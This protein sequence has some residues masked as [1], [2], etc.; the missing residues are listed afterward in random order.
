MSELVL[1]VTRVIRP[2]LRLLPKARWLKIVS[3][4]GGA[5]LAG[6]AAYGVTNWAAGLG[7]GS[8]GEAQSGTVANLSIT[9][10]ATPAASNV[11][12]P[13]GNGDVVITIANSN[14]FP[15]TITAVDL[16]T[17]LTYAAGFTTNSLGT[18][19]TGCSSTTSDVIWNYSTGTSGSTHSLT[20]P[21]VVG[22]SGQSNN[23]LVVTLTNDASMTTSS[24]SA[25]EGTFFSMPSFTGITAYGGT[26]TSST[27]PVTD[28]WTS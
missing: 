2:K 27:T 26:A 17:N 5:C 9:A 10:T 28:S 12:Y 23:P 22:A 7:A 4:V 13:G 15:V 18:A 21:L 6:G 19:Q 25:C 11:L 24:P 8:T 20:T 14:A 1:D 16:P 3:A